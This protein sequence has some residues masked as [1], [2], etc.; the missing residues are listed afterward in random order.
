MYTLCHRACNI[1]FSSDLIRKSST[2]QSEWKTTAAITVKV[3]AG[4]KHRLEMLA[5]ECS[6]VSSCTFG[7]YRH[8]IHDE[9]II[10]Q[11][12]SLDDMMEFWVKQRIKPAIFSQLERLREQPSSSSDLHWL[13]RG[14]ARKQGVS[15]KLSHLSMLHWNESNEAI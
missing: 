14:L 9:V 3:K 2:A 10:K 11:S 1:R 8:R 7:T 5:I 4:P 15:A 6:T 12:P 13:E